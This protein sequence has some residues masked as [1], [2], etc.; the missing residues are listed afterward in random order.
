MSRKTSK[1]YEAHRER[2]AGR[3]SAISLAGREIGDLPPIADPRRRARC[4]R[5]FR[6]FCDEYL[7]EAFPLAWSPD[8]LKV[9]AKAER[10]VLKGA[11]LSIAMPRGSG[12][13]T[14]SEALCLWAILYGHVSF[15]V[16]IAATAARGEA[17]LSG[18]KKRCE[19]TQSLLEDFPEA[20]YP[21]RALNR[22]VN[23]AAGQL[24]QGSPTL[25]E[26]TADRIVFPNI[27]GA[28]SAGACIAATGLEGGAIRGQKHT[29]PTGQILRPQLAVID[30]PQT[31]ESAWSPMQSQ[32]REAL[33]AGD[34]L[35]MAGPGVKIAGLLCCTVIRPGDMAD[36]ILNRDLHPEW[37]GERTKLLYAFPDNMDL[38]D[39]YAEIRAGELR[40]DGDGS[41]ATAFYIE[42]RAAMDAGAAVAWPERYNA[43][44]ASALQSAMNLYYR[45]RAAFF[46]EYQN[47]PEPE[48][49]A[50]DLRL[51]VD[52][53][54]AK[55]HGLARGIVPNSAS[56]LTAFID[57]HKDLLY[58]VVAAWEQNGTGYVIDYGTWPR[59]KKAYFLLRDARPTLS[60]MFPN[61]GWEGALYAGL[62]RQADDILA[63]EWKREN[64]TTARIRR[65]VVDAN[66]GEATELVY[67]W[68]RQSKHAGLILPSHGKY[69]GPN[70]TPF[71]AYR[72]K[73]GDHLGLNWRIPSVSQRRQIAHA[74]FD[75]NF[76]KTYTHARFL[77][78]LADPGSLSLFKHRDHRLYA[79][80]MEAENP[81][82][83]EGSQRTV[84]TWSQGPDRMDNHWLDCTVGAAVAASIEGCAIDQHRP[85]RRPSKPGQVR[86]RRQRVTTL[87]T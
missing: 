42:H 79:A 49:A 75:A 23:R 77:T 65:C 57:V 9:I 12:K 67:R 83:K 53:L 32:R 55:Q 15:V 8:H 52:Q 21:I 35:G 84:V 38:W 24:C 11:L 50:E 3:Q 58:F 34:V 29:L 71:S 16:L 81:E 30:D 44:E 17:M 18:I 4:R 14:L 51:S 26:W 82:R 73:E 47:T 70:S 68:A 61:A 31:T 46:A 80:H 28:A 45:D 72:R 41:H 33:L 7:P 74:T 69:V 25:I 64:N 39:R 19:H 60:S 20:V 48:T 27:A 66:W 85:Q 59:Q 5:S 22:I 36:R 10:A 76:W 54:A 56:V 1:A 6:R 43:D 40:E 87:S 13:T 37:Q 78:P 62:E 63:R 2:A 86:R